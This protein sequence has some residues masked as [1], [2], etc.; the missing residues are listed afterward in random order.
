MS[1][2]EHKAIARQLYEYIVSLPYGAEMSISEAFRKVYASIEV[3]YD[4]L[5]DIHNEVLTLF[6]SSEE[7]FFDPSEYIGAYAGFPYD[8]SLVIR[9]YDG[10]KREFNRKRIKNSGYRHLV[11]IALG[12][13]VSLDDVHE[14]S[15]GW[16]IVINGQGQFLSENISRGFEYAYDRS[17]PSYDNDRLLVN[18]SEEE[19]LVYYVVVFEKDTVVLDD[20]HEI[21]QIY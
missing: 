10:L 2:F 5:F 3:P 15:V 4:G 6:E 19:L 20:R 18:T 12:E 8:I 14:C 17:R 13:S 1:D 11:H 21:F 9:T 16:W 7:Y